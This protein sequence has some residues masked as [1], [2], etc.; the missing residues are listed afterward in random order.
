MLLTDH[1]G[2]DTT[3]QREVDDDAKKELRPYL[4]HLG[5]A[6]RRVPRGSP[7]GGELFVN[8]PN[9]FVQ[10]QFT[11][12]QAEV[13]NPSQLDMWTQDWRAQLTRA[14]LFDEKVNDILQILPGLQG[15]LDWS[16]V[17]TH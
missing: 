3:D 1:P 2:D 4:Q 8:Q 7:I 14:T 6:L 11:Y 13:Y 12:A 15:G 10:T 16:F 9:A 5:F 17:N